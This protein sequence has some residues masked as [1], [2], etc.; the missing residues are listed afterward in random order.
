[1]QTKGLLRIALVALMVLLVQGTWALA[2]TT[3]SITGKVSDQNGAAIS[4]AKVTVVSPSQSATLTSQPNGFYSA[5]NLSPDSYAIT[6]SKD[7]YDTATVYGITV[8]A[9]QSSRADISLRPATKVLGRVTTTATASIVSRTITG[10]LYSVNSSAIQ[11]YQG[12]AG[13]TETL[14]SQGSVVASLPGVVRNVGA[15][16]GYGGQ[17]ALSLRGGSPDQI[18]YELDGIP[19]NRGFD[20]YNGTAFLTNG[21]AGLE[22][23]TGGAPA[24]AGRAMSGYINEVIQRGKYPGGGDFTGVIGTPTFDHTVQADIYGGTPDNKFTYYVSTLAV[25]SAYNFGDRSNLD[26]TTLNI[27]AGDVG[28]GAAAAAGA[29]AASAC[30]P[31]GPTGQA[32]LLAGL[33]TNLPVSVGA[34]FST[35]YAAERDT[36]TNLHWGFDHSG[37]NDDL[38]MLYVTGTTAGPILYA[39]QGID[40]A[41]GGA[42]AI[43]GSNTITWPT[44]SLYTGG[45]GGSSLF[46]PTQSTTLT[47]PSSGG[48]VNGPVPLNYVDGSTTKYSIE[49]LGYTHALSQSSYINIYGYTLYSDWLTDG[50]TNSQNLGYQYQL[51][52]NATGF[53]AN[54]QNQINDKNLLKLTADYSRDRT[55]RYLYIVNAHTQ[56]FEGTNGGVGEPG[57]GV[58]CGNLSTFTFV[59]CVAGVTPVAQIRGPYDYWSSTIPVDTDVVLSDQFKPSDKLLFDLGVRFDRLGFD[60]MPLAI[61]GPNG[62]AEQ[63]QNKYGNC[64]F[65]YAYTAAEPCFGYLNFLAT[66]NLQPAF[67]PGATTWSDVSGTLNFN[68]VSPRFGLTFTANPQNVFRISVGRYVQPPNSA[69]EEYRANP[70]FGAGDTISILNRFYSAAGLNFHAVHNVLP[71]DSTNFDLSFEHEFGNGLSAKITPYYRNTRNQVL[72]LPVDPSN[73]TFVTGLNVGN[74][75]I[76]GVEFLMRKNVAGTNGIG[77]TLAAT[78]LDSK[79]RFTRGPSGISFIDIINKGITAYNTAYGTNFALEDP[80]AYYSP[81]FAQSPTLFTPS[82]DV[83]WT[84]NLNLDAR[85]AGFDLAPTFNYQSGNPYG[86]P[87]MFPDPGGKVGNGPDPYTKTFDQIGSLK[88]PSW[89]T[90]NLGVSHDLGH[91][92]KGSILMTNVFTQVHNH[93]YPWEYPTSKQVLNYSDNAFYSFEPFGPS[94]Y[95]GVNYYPYGPSSVNPYRNFVFSVSTKI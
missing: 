37:L 42:H 35:P 11:S 5:L 54:Y 31:A 34:Y 32:G 73:P 48:S 55:L 28:C 7:G 29:I 90:M 36:V 15:G 50:A 10:D 18:G 6:V 81:S 77:G 70:A 22:V 74:A 89:V 1:M 65:G 62:L 84:I 95:T 16:G 91:N 52:D 20:F 21:L 64:L 46:D 23:Y 94:A 30:G 25:N 92:V 83:R 41:H 68:E 43:L 9:D 17:G 26:N 14:Y 78:Y 33:T 51:H 79:L 40:P 39:G 13:G 93:G 61:N 38:Q 85:F 24:S 60:L 86:E 80:N 63:A 75:H 44:G 8:Q 4:G 58:T 66:S 76:K 45:V 67:A 56:D 49:K 71:E 12:A 82:Y 59:T 69:F 3:G 53:T 19:L 87:L 57:G 88:G 2:D 47:W 27:P 72:T